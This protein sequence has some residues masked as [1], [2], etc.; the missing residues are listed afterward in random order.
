MRYYNI[1]NK[2]YPHW[3]FDFLNYNGNIIGVNYFTSL[4]DAS[5]YLGITQATLSSQYYKKR[6]SKIGILKYIKISKTKY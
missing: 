2:F 6:L 4:K 1:L 3:R 5:K